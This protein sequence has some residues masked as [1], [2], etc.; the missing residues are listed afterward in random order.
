MNLTALH[1]AVGRLCDIVDQL[2]SDFPPPKPVPQGDGYVERHDENDR[3]NSLACYLKAVKICS[4]LNGAIVLVANHHAQEAHALCRIAQ[5]QIDD[6]HLLLQPR[7]QDGE[8][9]AQQHRALREFYQEEFEDPADPV[10]TSQVRDRIARQKVQAAINNDLVDPSSAQM[11]TMALYRMFSGYVHGAYVHIMELHSDTPGRYH[12]HGA[13]SR[14][15]EAV[16][17]VANYAYR[18]M[19]AVESLVKVCA[20]A[21]LLPLITSLR[22]EVAATFDLLPDKA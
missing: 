16:E 8:L 7:A 5:D 10:G 15:Q 20:R 1:A 18:A 11:T 4:T 13:P 3:T 2:G 6:I 14:T 9:S 22:T 19:L 12:L 21:D 17:S